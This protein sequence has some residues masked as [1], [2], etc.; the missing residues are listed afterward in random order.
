VFTRYLVVGVLLAGCARPPAGK[1][2]VQPTPAA[3]AA[4][5]VAASAPSTVA[6]ASEAVEFSRDVEPILSSRC[7]PCHFEGGKVY[8]RL[9]FDRPATIRSLGEKLFT[10]IKDEPSQATIRTFL[11]RTP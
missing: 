8:A 4:A 7:R 6:R 5:P 10:R 11:A 2:Q 3:M 9:P 1:P